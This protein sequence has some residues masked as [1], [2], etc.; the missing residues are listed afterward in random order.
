VKTAITG[1]SIF[2]LPIVG[3]I[4]L[5][6]DPWVFIHIPSI[7]FVVIA[8]GGLALMRYRKGQGKSAI[9]ENFRKY[10]IPAGVLGCLVG[11][12]QSCRHLSDLEKLPAAMG[13]AVLSVFYGLILYCVLDTFTGRVRS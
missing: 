10:V 8:A 11:F 3:C 4:I 6:G 7:G 9:V 13:V 12:V 5:G 2:L 1:F